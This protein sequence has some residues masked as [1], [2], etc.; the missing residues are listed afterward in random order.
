ML[1]SVGHFQEKFILGLQYR[2]RGAEEA[3][4]Q[5]EQGRQGELGKRL[6]FGKLTNQVKGKRNKFNLS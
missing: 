3:E 1:A 4:G 6:W 5:G 2:A